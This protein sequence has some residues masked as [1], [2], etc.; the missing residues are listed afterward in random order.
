MKPEI[1]ARAKANQGTRT[2]LLVNSPKSHAPVDT[3]KRMAQAVGIGEQAMGRIAQLAE[4]APPSLKGALENKKVSVNRGWK[5]LK[6]VQQLPQEEQES[7]AVEMLS[8]VREIDRMDAEADSRHKIA[9][10]FCKAY[11]Q[12]V[13]LTP[14]LENIRFWV[15]CTRMRPDKVEDSVKESYALAQ[16]FQTIGDLLKNEMLN[17]SRQA[18]VPSDGN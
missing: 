8:A 13:L 9:S 16:T 10:L 17:T 1:E 4:N 6:A 2:D 18:G 7:A 15:E 11:E 3:R 14:T 5:I 12:A